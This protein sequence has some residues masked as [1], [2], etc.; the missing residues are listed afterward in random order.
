MGC[1]SQKHHVDLQCHYIT[2]NQLWQLCM[3]NGPQQN[4]N[5]KTKDT[6]KSNIF[7]NIFIA[8]DSEAEAYS[9]AN[10]TLCNVQQ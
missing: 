8:A 2:K 1:K 10:I 4:T 9:M 3:G 6:P 5:N 7:T